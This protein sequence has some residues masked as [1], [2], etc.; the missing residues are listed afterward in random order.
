MAEFQP[1]QKAWHK[2]HGIVTV[3]YTSGGY[4]YVITDDTDE[5]FA[6]PVSELQ[7]LDDYMEQQR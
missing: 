4:A 2:V 1:N 6:V 7:D 5:S 3:L